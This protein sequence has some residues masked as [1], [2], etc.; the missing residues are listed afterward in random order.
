MYGLLY[1]LL[2]KSEIFF[3]DD[4]ISAHQAAVSKETETSWIPVL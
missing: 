3:K 4:L 2:K 1:I